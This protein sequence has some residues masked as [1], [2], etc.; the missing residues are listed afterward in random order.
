MDIKDREKLKEL[1]KSTDISNH[2]LAIEIAMNT[3]DM[4]VDDLVKLITL[5]DVEYNDFRWG[6]STYRCFIIGG[7]NMT[8]MPNKSSTVINARAVSRNNIIKYLEEN[9]ET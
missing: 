9:E 1:I 3:L 5:D 4:T 7:D 8:G 6:Y 2:Y